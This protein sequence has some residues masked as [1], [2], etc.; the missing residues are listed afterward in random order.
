M[1]MLTFQA[2]QARLQAY[3]AQRETHEEQMDRNIKKFTE[4]IAA[5]DPD[6]QNIKLHNDYEDYIFKSRQA[7]HVGWQVYAPSMTA[8]ASAAIALILA[9]YT[10]VN[11]VGP[12]TPTSIQ[13]D[14]VFRIIDASGTHASSN[15][16]AFKAAGLITLKEDSINKLV[17]S[18]QTK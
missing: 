7:N 9:A 11:S 12:S 17:E 8:V 18:W 13:A 10:I 3:K 2:L 14:I 4:E 15:L 5:K 16:K 1:K 6:L